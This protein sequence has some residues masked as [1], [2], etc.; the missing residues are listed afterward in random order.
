[1]YAKKYAPHDLNTFASDDYKLD[2]YMG[3]V[4]ISGLWAQKGKV[5]HVR[6]VPPIPPCMEQGCLTGLGAWT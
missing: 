6:D 1:L 2:M 4:F 5:D 3:M